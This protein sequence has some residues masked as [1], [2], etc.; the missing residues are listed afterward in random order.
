[1]PKYMLLSKFVDSGF[2]PGHWI[3]DVTLSER[4]I[5]QG[6]LFGNVRVDSIEAA[7]KVFG[8]LLAGHELGEN[9][10]ACLI[11]QEFND[12]NGG[13]VFEMTPGVARPGGGYT[14]HDTM[15]FAVRIK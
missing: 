1:M 5:E 4:T 12:G 8:D 15:R 14:L 7:A 3:A 13:V 10:C 2:G 6:A 9:F 11:S